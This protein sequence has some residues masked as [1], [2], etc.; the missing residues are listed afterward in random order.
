VD[1]L[2]AQALAAK[3]DAAG[4]RRVL[5]PIESSVAGLPVFRRAQ[6]TLELARTRAALGD[7]EVARILNRAASHLAG[8][9]GFR[10][11]SLQSLLLAVTLAESDGERS[12]LHAN[13]AE[14]VDEVANTLSPAWQVA[15]RARMDPGA[16]HV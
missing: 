14:Y 1:T 16:V 8:M 11:L 9:R 3:G 4:A 15:F 2:E 13:A 12:R 5:G 7:L 6:V 10:L